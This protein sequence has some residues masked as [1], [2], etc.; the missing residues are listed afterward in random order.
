M[1][2]IISLTFIL[3]VALIAGCSGLQTQPDPI[4]TPSPEPPAPSVEEI[5]QE[6]IS[7]MNEGDV[8]KSLDYFADDA[9][10][11]IVGLPPTGMEVY[12]GKDQIRTLWQDSV[13]NKFQWEIES[14]SVDGNI[15]YVLARTWHDFTRQLGVAP[16]E[17]N[18]IY[19]VKDGK[20]TTYGTIITEESLV[21]F[22]PAFAE[23][24]PL[25]DPIPSTE[26]PVSEMV[27]T[28]VDGTCLLDQSTPLQ[29]GEINI[30]WKI[31]D[32]NKDQ[33]ALTLFTLNEDK[34]LLDLMSTT[35]GVPPS[36]ADMLFIEE[37]N[38]GESQMY[39]FNVEKGPIYMICWSNPPDLPIGNAGPIEI[40]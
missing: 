27:V 8:E 37:L 29:A 32:V 15:V 11:Y 22:K 26:K 35:A 21:R 12:A 17:Y 40:K 28:I 38:P 25:E 20:I 10:V 6:M 4:P 5:V 23:V 39:T 1:K 34:D 7:Y 2:K 16:L 33:Y 19:E 36:W 18:D 24:V 14:V 3:L 9:V 30:T 13:D 31:A